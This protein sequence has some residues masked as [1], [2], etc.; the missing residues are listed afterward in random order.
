M[1]VQVAIVGAGPLRCELE[2]MAVRSGV[3][4]QVEFLGFRSDVHRLVKSSQVFVLPSAY[5]GLSISLVDAMVSGI[6]VIS[7][8]VGEVR[9][10]VK[11]GTSGMLYPSGDVQA[12]ADA[13]QKLLTDHAL[14]A[15][16][17]RNGRSS[18]MGEVSPTALSQR[19]M[20]ELERRRPTR[21]RSTI[22]GRRVSREAR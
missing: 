18:A 13:L 17:A 16:L 15:E 8:D 14:R 5:E 9:E 3:G 19:V 6:A 20:T 21:N 12:L 10:V 7:S 4:H 1:C 2:E 22:S 11:D